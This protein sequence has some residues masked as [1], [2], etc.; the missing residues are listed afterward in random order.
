MRIY[1]RILL[2]LFKEASVGFIL[3]LGLYWEFLSGRLLM[4]QV[5]SLFRAPQR[6]SK[7]ILLVFYRL[8][9]PSRLGVGTT[10]E[11][12]LKLL[13]ARKLYKKG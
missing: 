10:Y 1:F 2:V 9:V 5:L 4:V 13:L 11:G 12:Y 7:T 6:A 3:E 8:R